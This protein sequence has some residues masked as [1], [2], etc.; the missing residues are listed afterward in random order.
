MGFMTRRNLQRRAAEKVAPRVT[1][2][3]VEKTVEKAVETVEEAVE[4]VEEKPSVTRE[5]VMS[6]PFFKVKAV[7][8]ANG[9]D[10]DKKKTAELREAVLQK[11]GL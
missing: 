6:M 1:E 2:K 9:I 5:E 8:Q 3:A 10:T 11:L 7:A 4:T